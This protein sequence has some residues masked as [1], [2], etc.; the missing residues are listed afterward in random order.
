MTNL[1]TRH[2]RIPRRTC[3]LPTALTTLETVW[4]SYTSLHMMT[5]KH[6]VCLRDQTANQCLSAVMIGAW[7]R[8]AATREYLTGLGNTAG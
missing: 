2:T 3:P 7:K 5:N 8:P 4:V 1:N 6:E